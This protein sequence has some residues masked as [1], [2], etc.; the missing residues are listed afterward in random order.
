MKYIDIHQTKDG[1]PNERSLKYS[2]GS[3]FHTACLVPLNVHNSLGKPS[4]DTTI[5][6]TGLG[7]VVIH[8]ATCKLWL[9][10]TNILD[11][12]KSR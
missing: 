1:Y 11:I 2:K 9:S 5:L 12:I 3:C 10:I 7:F 8:I 4:L 6:N